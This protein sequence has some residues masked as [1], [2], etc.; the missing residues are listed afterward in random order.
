MISFQWSRWFLSNIQDPSI[1]PILRSL[2]DFQII[3]NRPDQTIEIIDKYFSLS[4]S[5]HILSTSYR[6]YWFLYDIQTSINNQYYYIW[7]IKLNSINYSN[8]FTFD[9]DSYFSLDG[10][11][12]L[13]LLSPS[14]QTKQETNKL[15][16]SISKY[17]Q[18]NER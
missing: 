14:H 4:F 11:K 15:K 6:I 18:G 5:Y 17:L 9:P 10:F 13:Q 1:F 12:I 8:H 7:I 16:N 2:S 3:S